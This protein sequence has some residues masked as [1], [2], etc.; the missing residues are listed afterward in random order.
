MPGLV[1][2]SEDETGYGKFLGRLRII[3]T[4]YK[5]KQLSK[6]TYS[7][8]HSGHSGSSKTNPSGGHKD[9]GGVYKD[10]LKI[11]EGLIRKH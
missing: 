5:N 11:A 8:S 3:C 1:T 9:S 7:S 2:E 6:D 10:Y 4:N